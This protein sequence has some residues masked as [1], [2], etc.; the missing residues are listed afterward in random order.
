MPGELAIW[1]LPQPDWTGQ[2]AE[3]RKPCEKET[4]IQRQ[5]TSVQMEIL[6]EGA[7]GRQQIGAGHTSR[8][9]IVDKKCSDVTAIRCHSYPSEQSIRILSYP[10]LNRDGPKSF[11]SSIRTKQDTY[12]VHKF[13]AL[14]PKHGAKI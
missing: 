3:G 2:G 9:E 5:A 11:P 14:W 1:Q 8:S 12:I 6:A 7:E 13:T 10:L 4:D